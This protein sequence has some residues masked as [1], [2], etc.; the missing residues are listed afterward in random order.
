MVV[1]MQIS[2][3]TAMAWGMRNVNPN[4]QNITQEQ[5]QQTALDMKEN[6]SPQIAQQIWMS[7]LFAYKNVS[8]DELKNYL[9][10]NETTKGQRTLSF[11][12]TVYSDMHQHTT[13]QLQYAL[14]AEFI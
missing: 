4:A 11:I 6:M 2:L 12:R 10:L 9:T 8:D 7:M 3:F 13:K 5:L 1:E 14:E